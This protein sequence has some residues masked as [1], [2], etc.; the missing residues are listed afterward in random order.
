MNICILMWVCGGGGE[1]LL[2]HSDSELLLKNS[3]L[4]TSN[5][6]VNFS[7]RLKLWFAVSFFKI[8]SALMRS[9]HSY[10]STSAAIT[11]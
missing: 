8:A 5:M 3:Q 11:K 1:P 2:S 7:L 6:I 10:V 9:A 4:H